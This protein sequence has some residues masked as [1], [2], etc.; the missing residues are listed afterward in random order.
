MDQDNFQITIS[1][2]NGNWLT[3]TGSYRGEL[4][5]LLQFLKKDG[6]QIQV[7]TGELNYF[8]TKPIKEE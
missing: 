4:N 7:S 8:E 2:K 1:T 3:F 5:G 6:G